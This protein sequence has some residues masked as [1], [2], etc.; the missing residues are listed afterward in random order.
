MKA[1]AGPTALSHELSHGLDN[2]HGTV[3]A[4]AGVM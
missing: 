2:S 1:D 4:V 3:L